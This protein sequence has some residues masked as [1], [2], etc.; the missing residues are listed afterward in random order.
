MFDFVEDFFHKQFFSNNHYED[1]M[2]KFASWLFDGDYTPYG[3]VF[4]YV[5]TTYKE[6]LIINLKIVNLFFRR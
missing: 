2:E 6:L 5:I 4:D 3:G 1:I